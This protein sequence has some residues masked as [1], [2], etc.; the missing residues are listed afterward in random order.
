MT[1]SAG[2]TYGAGIEPTFLPD[3]SCKEL[4]WQI[5]GKRGRT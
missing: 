4:N 3:Q 1:L 5:I 2:A